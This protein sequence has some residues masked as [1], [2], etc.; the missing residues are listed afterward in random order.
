MHL[1]ETPDGPW[2]CLVSFFRVVVSPHGPGHLAILLLEPERTNDPREPANVCYTDNEPLARYVLEKL[3]PNIDQLKDN[4]NLE[5]LPIVLADRFTHQG[6]HTTEWTERIEGNG[7]EVMLTWGELEQPFFV[8]QGPDQSDTGRREQFSL[9]VPARRA[10]VNTNGRPGR[11]APV[12]LDEP[13]RQGT[14]A[15][16]AFSETWLRPS[17]R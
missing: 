8:E 9:Y 14:T 15:Y 5:S 6:S 3:V 4:P 12:P 2:S 7:I 16:L 1:K 17:N 10:E 13:G 11:G